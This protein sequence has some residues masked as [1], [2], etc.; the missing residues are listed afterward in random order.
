MKKRIIGIMLA[1]VMA[2]SLVPVTVF[3]DTDSTIE[4]LGETITYSSGA[5]VDWSGIEEESNLI[6]KFPYAGSNS[7]ADYTLTLPADMN[8]W[9]LVV[10]GGASGATGKKSTSGKTVDYRGAGGGGGKVLDTGKNYMLPAGT[11]TIKVGAGGQSVEPANSGSATKGKAGTASSV[12]GPVSS[13][14]YNLIAEGGIAGADCGTPAKSGSDAVEPL[15]GFGGGNYPSDI[16]GELITYGKDGL[17]AESST[18]TALSGATAGAGGQGGG[19]TSTAK[20]GAGAA[21]TVIVRLWGKTQKSQ[22]LKTATWESD[23]ENIKARLEITSE[24]LPADE[25]NLNILFLGGLC[26]AHSLDQDIVKD[27]LNLC[28]EYGRVDYYLFRTG[29]DLKTDINIS[30][31][32]LKDQKITTN[33]ELAPSKHSV[34]F[35]YADVLANKWDD[36]YDIVIM[37]CDAM[38][39]GVFTPTPSDTQSSNLLKAAQKLKKLYA[40]NKVLLIIP[41]KGWNKNE[42]DPNE[43]AASYDAKYIY[44]EF[45][46]FGKMYTSGGNTAYNE[47]YSKHVYDSL[48]LLAPED[49][50]NEEGTARKPYPTLNKDTFESEDNY[51]TL[52]SRFGNESDDKIWECYDNVE[53]VTGFFKTKLKPVFNQVVLT[54]TVADGFEIKSVSGMYFDTITDKYVAI[55]DSSNIFSYT[56]DTENKQKVYGVFDVSTLVTPYVKMLINIETVTGENYPFKENATADTNVGDATAG[57]YVGYG[58]E[59]EISY[60]SNSVETPSLTCSYT[61]IDIPEGAVLKFNGQTQ[62]GVPES[63]DYTLEGD[64]SE[65][66]VDEYTVTAT[67]KDTDN[68]C[69]SDGTQTPKDIDWSIIPVDTYAITVVNNE[70]GTVKAKVDGLEASSAAEGDTVVLA[71][72]PNEGYQLKS[73]KYNDGTD[74]TVSADE[75][76]AYKFTMPAKDVTV[77]SEFEPI[78]HTHSFTY[79][80][81]DNVLEATCTDGCPDEYDTEPLTLT[82]TAPTDPVYDGT[83]KEATI[84]ASEKAAWVDAGLTVPTVVYTK[85]NGTSY[86]PISEVPTDAGSYY[87]YIY[88]EE[89]GVD[90]HVE[91]TIAPRPV[92]LVANDAEKV[93]DGTPLTEGGFVVKEDKITPNYGFVGSEGIES[94]AMTTESTITFSGTQPNVIES[95]TPKSNTNLDNYTVTKESGTLTVTHKHNLVPVDGQAPTEEAAGWKDYYE[96]NGDDDGCGGCFEDATGLTPIENIDEWKSEGG[97]GYIP[98]LVHN[99]IPVNGKDPTDTEGGY[100]PY[101][102]CDNCGNA[103]YEDALGLVKIPDIDV[104]KAEGG[105]GYI[106]PLHG[107][108]KNNDHLCDAC[109][110]PISNHVDANNDH[111]CDICNEIISNHQDTDS[112]HKCDICD[113]VISN[114]V[115]DNSD[116]ICDICEKIITN[117]IDEDKDHICDICGKTI[118]NHEDT[119]PKDHICDY[120]DEVISNHTDDNND[121]ICDIC[122]KVISNHTDDNSDH[123]CDICDKAINNHEDSDPKDHICDYCGKTINNHLDNNTDH[124]CDYCSKTVSN[125]EGKFRDGLEPTFQRSGYK[126]YYECYC[127]KYFEDATCRIEIENLEMWKAEGGN[128]YLPKLEA[129]ISPDTGYT[130]NIIPLVVFILLTFSAVALCGLFIGKNKE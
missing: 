92:V 46:L 33:L 83:E 7:T 38:R 105:D 75:H 81:T 94:V 50:L 20:S 100:L 29:N 111:F 90:A 13:D 107:T 14:F 72:E 47:T 69:W 74:H 66:E 48:A 36:K 59:K 91:F 86:E 60:G 65:V 9:V 84:P 27:S 40:E 118:S 52:K 125:H 41:D 21:G 62:S 119:D 23:A 49:W 101:Y 8:A 117:H 97:N 106:P 43:E 1:V 110:K 126:S 5:T 34:M 17:K 120:C 22:L 25:D 79:S 53:K 55:P 32:L 124:I 6:L 45:Y 96:C 78:P 121:H 42:S 35:E 130:D 76:G 61:I 108:D 99:P 51:K 16:T 98:P 11:Y 4:F 2:V 80:A 39:M 116:H 12:I 95:I 57:Y 87:A 37:E 10:G 89:D 64:V 82:L 15:D 88:A 68:T 58:T 85:W 73:I 56:F 114:H 102:A 115:D 18:Q 63:T 67:L 127:G 54:D 31:T 123:I 77:T 128:G 103:Y 28:S 109:D 122:D 26:S 129:E 93:Y 24:H 30:G 113:K 44:N 104:W 19:R 71:V 70:N 112:N 3:A